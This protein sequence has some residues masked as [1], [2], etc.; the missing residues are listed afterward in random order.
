MAAK[1]Q[2]PDAVY[3][4]I[5][6]LYKAGKPF[7]AIATE[8]NVGRGTV[9]TALKARGVERR[10]ATVIA[11]RQSKPSAPAKAPLPIIQ[12]GCG[13]GCGRSFQRVLGHRCR[14]YAPGCPA[15]AEKKRREAIASAEKR[16]AERAARS[17]PRHPQGGKMPSTHVKVRWCEACG[18][19]SWRREQPL[20]S[21]EC[22]LPYAPEPGITDAERSVIQR[23]GTCEQ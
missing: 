2:L 23:S 11:P 18:G 5:V 19:M 15:Y 9:Y 12:C 16:R 4:R 14:K 20:C 8:C 22:G 21:G 6:E 1:Q 10:E 7:L 13:T 3:D 17:A